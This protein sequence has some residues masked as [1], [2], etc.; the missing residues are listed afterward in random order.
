[1]MES[2]RIRRRTE[3]LRMREEEGASLTSIAE[4]VGLSTRTVRRWLARA[5]SGR[6][7]TAG[8]GAWAADRPRSGAPRRLNR[9]DD[10]IIA[11]KALVSRERPPASLRSLARFAGARR[12]RGVSHTTVWRHLRDRG[13]EYLPPT[14]EVNGRLVGAT[15]LRDDDEP[16]LWMAEVALSHDG[17]NAT[18]WRDRWSQVAQATSERRVRML[19]GVCARGGIGPFRLPNRPMSDAETKGL[20]DDL[21]DPRL[22]VLY[23]PGELDRARLRT[24]VALSP[25]AMVEA[26][27]SI[28]LE[29]S[30]EPPEERPSEPMLRLISCVRR[31]ADSAARRRSDSMAGGRLTKEC[32]VDSLRRL[33][34]RMDERDQD[35][36]VRRGVMR[37]PISRLRERSSSARRF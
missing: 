27:R 31:A 26:L 2:E 19:C 35:R 37:R 3:I 22:A 11:R 21:L 36:R 7:G 12:G 8:R 5:A 34:R 23:L 24:D 30:I 28:R 25:A 9:Q 29:T 14:E 33:A 20:V 15:P 4:A 6:D 18:A 17:G 10:L 13:I 16:C 32:V 1:M